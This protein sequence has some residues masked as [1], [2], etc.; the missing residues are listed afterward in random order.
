MGN[1]EGVKW[2]LLPVLQQVIKE[3]TVEE[4]VGKEKSTKSKKGWISDDSEAVAN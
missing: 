4:A 3:I 1:F 2:E